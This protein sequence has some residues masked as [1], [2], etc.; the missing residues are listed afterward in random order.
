MTTEVKIDRQEIENF[1]F[2]EARLIDDEKFEEWVDLFTE[3][4]LYWAPCNRNEIDPSREVSLV[5]DDKSRMLDR[6]WRLRSGLAYSQEPASRTR[7]MISNVEIVEAGAEKV[8]VSSNFAI[9]ENRRGA[10]KTFAGRFEHHL[11]PENGSWKIAF[12]KVEL[13]NNDDPIDNLTFLL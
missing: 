7:H 6:V 12:K 5:Y 8:V 2:K 11:R 4:T 1:L 3:D 10:Q 9:F 13:I